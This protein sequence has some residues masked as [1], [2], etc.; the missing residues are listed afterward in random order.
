MEYQGGQDVAKNVARSTRPRAERCIKGALHRHVGQ[1]LAL[2][3]GQQDAEGRGGAQRHA[4]EEEPKEY[5]E[6]V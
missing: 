6:P 1:N 4:D 3:S 2:G 5:P